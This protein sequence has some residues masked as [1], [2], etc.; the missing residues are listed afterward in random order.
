[1][2][3]CQTPHFDVKRG[4]TFR[5]DWH[6]AEYENGLEVARVSLAGVAVSS[7]IRDQAGVLVDTAIVTITDEAAGEY[8]VEFD[9]AG[10]AVGASY[11]SDIRFE[12]P[13]MVIHTVTLIVRVLQEVTAP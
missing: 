5:R 4:S 3:A 1:M 6:L 10:W 9:T 2:M 7:Q 8:R 11:V 12:F 13:D